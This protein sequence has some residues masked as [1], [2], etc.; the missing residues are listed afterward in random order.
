MTLFPNTYIPLLQSLVQLKQLQLKQL[1]IFHSIYD[2]ACS[3]HITQS[4]STTFSLPFIYLG[5][6]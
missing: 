1:L 3:F 2:Y 5:L 6:V 4:S